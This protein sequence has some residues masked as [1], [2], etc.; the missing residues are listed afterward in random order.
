MKIQNAKRWAVAGVEPY[1]VG[2]L[3]YLFAFAVRYTLHPM[4]DDH[5]SMFFFAVN[6]VVV[7]FLYGLAPSLFTLALSLPTA[8]YFFIKPFNSFSSPSEED[9]FVLIVYVTLVSATA[10]MVELLRREKYKGEL[11][12]RVSDCRYQLL[13]DADEDR[14]NILR[15]TAVQMD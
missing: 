7:A 12:L 5:M 11:L 9:L 2:F 14:R 15:E 8:F 13:L 1:C 4:L 3:G 10:I 6:S